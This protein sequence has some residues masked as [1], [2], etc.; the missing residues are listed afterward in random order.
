MNQ[1]YWYWI[2]D[3]VNFYI[4]YNFSNF[5][6]YDFISLILGILKTFLVNLEFYYD[7]LLIKI[8]SGFFFFFE[9]K[10]RNSGMF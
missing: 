4:W 6:F 10:D 7:T 2:K 3:G 9:R 1:T 5:R 8:Y